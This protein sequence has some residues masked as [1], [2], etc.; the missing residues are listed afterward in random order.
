MKTLQT[1]KL[2]QLEGGQAFPPPKRFSPRCPKGTFPI[3]VSALWI[4]GWG[5]G[6]IL[7][8]DLDFILRA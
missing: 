8:G 3:A 4:P 5:P 2:V 1:N 7:C 6:N